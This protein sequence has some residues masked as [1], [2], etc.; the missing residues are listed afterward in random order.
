VPEGPFDYA[1]TDQPLPRIGLK[2]AREKRRMA[3]IGRQFAA[4]ADQQHVD[5]FAQTRELVLVV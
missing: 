3:G 5:R 4:G 1:P 2:P